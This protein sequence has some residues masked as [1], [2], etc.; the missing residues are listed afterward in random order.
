MTELTIRDLPDVVH[1]RLSERAAENGRTPA[2]EARVALEDR[3]CAEDKANWEKDWLRAVES[4]RDDLRAA[5]T[6]GHP[7]GVVDEF[8]A[9]K[10]LIAAVQRALDEAFSSGTRRLGVD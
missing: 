1:R 3:Y 8:L 4:I 10:R 2:D 7:I 5:S 6:E 9:E